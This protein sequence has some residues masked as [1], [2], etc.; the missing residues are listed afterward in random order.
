MG[1]NDKYSYTATRSTYSTNTTYQN[2]E[3][4]TFTP[5]TTGDYLIIANAIFDGAST[6][7]QAKARMDLDGSTQWSEALIQPNQTVNRYSYGA[8]YKVNL[9]NASHSINLQYGTNNT[10]GAVGMGNRF[11]C[12]IRLDAF[13]YN[14]STIDDTRSTYATDTNYQDKITD[15]NSYSTGYYLIIGSA[16]FDGSATT[17]QTWCSIREGTSTLKAE[18]GLAVYNAA[19]RHPFLGSYV[20]SSTT[21]VVNK[22]ISYG[23]GN[24]GH[25]A[26]VANC[27][28]VGLRL[29]DGIWTGT[30]TDSFTA[31]DNTN[32]IGKL[33]MPVSSIDSF[34]AHGV[35][36]GGPYTFANTST[37]S[38][39]EDDQLIQPTTYIEDNFDDNTLAVNNWIREITAGGSVTETGRKLSIVSGDGFVNGTTCTPNGVY[40]IVASGDF[41]VKTLLNNDTMVAAGLLFWIDATHYIIMHSDGYSGYKTGGSYG[42][43]KG[44]G[45][46][47]GIYVRIKRVG[48]TCTVYTSDDGTT[49]T[50]AQQ[51]QSTGSGAGRIYLHANDNS[52]A[53]FTATFAWFG[54]TTTSFGEMYDYSASDSF[55]CDDYSGAGFVTSHSGIDSFTLDDASTKTQVAVSSGI[56][57]FT[58]D[59]SSSRLITFV[60]TAS[61]SFTEDDTST[62]EYIQGVIEKTAYDSFTADDLS[63]TT[64][65]AVSSGID[66]FTADDASTRNTTYISSSIDS[67][68]EHGVATN[69]GIF[70]SSG[71]DSFTADD[72][73]SNKMVFTL[74]GI[75]SFTGDDVATSRMT[76]VVSG[77][78][79]YTLDDFSART[80]ICVSAVEDIVAF[81]DTATIVQTFVNSVADIFTISGSSTNKVVFA[82][83]N[84]DS[85][86]EHDVSTYQ[87]IGAGAIMDETVSDSFTL[88]DSTSGTT[89]INCSS[90]DVIL[91]HTTASGNIIIAV[92]ALDNVVFAD[93]A[94]RF[95]T[96]LSSAT[97]SINL[98]D[99]S[100]NTIVIRIN[101]DD[102][103]QFNDVSASIL[104]FAETAS[105]G[106]T[107]TGLTEAKIFIAVYTFKAFNK[108]FHFEV[109][110]KQF[111]SQANEIE[112][113]TE[114][115]PRI[116][117]FVAPTK[118][119]YEEIIK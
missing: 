17:Y 40:Q 56:D 102:V 31:D 97:D 14:Y 114:A 118:K 20:L 112:F 48:S 68:T 76:F 116:F 7:Y 38:F 52:G 41:D 47:E 10:G 2:L 84:Q 24:T 26:G 117:H 30:S 85:F 50:A 13:D 60:N 6:S 70:N 43:S 25:T 23:T 111:A 108:T 12:A 105:D 72:A 21:G 11:I 64:Q 119:S 18:S 58:A 19:N 49:W 80:Q 33:T 88:N 103:A 101:V 100:I 22:K 8:I 94:T 98:D 32:T 109:K 67:F 4:L 69:S 57:S 106:F 16:T 62:Y 53:G 86:T 99:A 87:F 35:S 66:S 59:D 36:S 91:F 77:S 89:T 115:R 39:T 46:Y 45:G 92:S 61:D 110:C 95:Q 55:T 54:N 104:H 42:Y 15:S 81:N 107:L 75:D 34:T 74:S 93:D 9:S 29:F 113:Y 1:T 71:I 83:S 82:C 27:R 3:T 5:G 96:M 63:S 90:Q 65:V 51:T 37:D 78:D 73:A 79:S 44:A 28:L